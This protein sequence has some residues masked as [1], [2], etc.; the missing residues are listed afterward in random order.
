MLASAMIIGIV[1]DDQETR[2]GKDETP[3]TRGD[4]HGCRGDIRAHCGRW[5]GAE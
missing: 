1:A 3:S 2:Y 4:E 5:M